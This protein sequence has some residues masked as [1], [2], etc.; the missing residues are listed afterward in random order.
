MI[1][2]LVVED[3]QII[4]DGIVFLLEKEGYHVDTAKNYINALN[5]IDRKYYDLAI[6]DLGLPDGNGYD[7]CERMKKKHGSNV[8]FLTAR[9]EEKDIVKGLDMGGDDYITKPFRIAELLSR[10]KAVLRRNSGQE[11]VLNLQ[12]LIIYSLKGKVYRNNQ[13][14]FL[15]AMEYRLLLTFAANKNQIL[16]RDQLLSN[17]WDISDDLVNDNTLTVYI[18]RLREKIEKDPQSPRII[19]TIRGIG[20]VGKDL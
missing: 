13:E 11:K 3:D 19:I 16:T 5:A 8:I 12:D 1:E 17:I 7:L 10:I 14:I 4:L 15:S 9:D 6:L 18:K 2:V 20:Y